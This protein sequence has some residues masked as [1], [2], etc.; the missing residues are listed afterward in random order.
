MKQNLVLV[1]IFTDHMFVMNYDE[2]QGWHD[3]RIVPYGPIE[4]DPSADAFARWTNCIEGMKA[5]RAKGRT[6]A[7][8][9]S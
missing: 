3:A 4:L 9:P 6:R 5:Y 2:G 1:R 7:V 8:I